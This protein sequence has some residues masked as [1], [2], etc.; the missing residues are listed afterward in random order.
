M[1]DAT[2][3]SFLTSLE[4]SNSLPIRKGNVRKFH[5]KSRTGCQRCRA[6]RV[7]VSYGNFISEGKYQSQAGPLSRR[8]GV[9]LVQQHPSSSSVADISIVQR[10]KAGLP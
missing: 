2:V 10:G 4:H 9:T 1:S 3:P 8:R 6:R 5:K 7:K